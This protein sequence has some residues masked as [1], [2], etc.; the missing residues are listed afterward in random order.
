VLFVEK[1]VVT[2]NH[3]DNIFATGGYNIVEV[4]ENIDVNYVVAGV[5]ID[6]RYSKFNLCF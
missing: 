5:I 6:H 2:L 3:L 1:P 4:F